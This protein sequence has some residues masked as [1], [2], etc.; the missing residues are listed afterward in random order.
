M[1]EPIEEG[2]LSF[3]LDE[4]PGRKAFIR[5]TKATDAYIALVQILNF[6]TDERPTATYADLDAI[7]QS[8]GL[9]IWEEL[10]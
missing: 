6:F 5:A 10:S 8:L 2:I 1:K 3:N 7:I 9:D 4:P